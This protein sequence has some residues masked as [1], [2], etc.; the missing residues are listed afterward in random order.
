MMRLTLLANRAGSSFS[1]SDGV[2]V[3]R[4]LTDRIVFYYYHHYHQYKEMKKLQRKLEML[5]WQL[6]EISLSTKIT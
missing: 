2:Y 4:Y 3:G 5:D 6:T 1:S